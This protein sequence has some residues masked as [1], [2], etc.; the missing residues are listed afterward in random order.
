MSL[1]ILGLIY[2]LFLSCVEFL[3]ASRLKPYLFFFLGAVPL[4]IFLGF[5][6]DV[7]QDYYAYIR[8]FEIA[9]NLANFH[10]GLQTYREQTS[11]V[12]I[13]FAVLASL[14]RTL[15]FTPQGGLFVSAV[16]NI[17][18]VSILILRYGRHYFFSLSI[19][20]AVFLP[21]LF[22]HLR[23]SLCIPLGMLGYLLWMERKRKWAIFLMIFSASFHLTGLIYIATSLLSSF[24]NRFSISFIGG[25]SIF[26]SLILLAPIELRPVLNYGLSLIAERYEFYSNSEGA[27]P[28]AAFLR[29][30]ILFVFMVSLHIFKFEE[31]ADPHEQVLG[32]QLFFA[33]SFSVVLWCLSTHIDIFYRL[34]LALQASFVLIFPLLLRFEKTRTVVSHC[35]YFAM[36]AFLLAYLVYLSF[37]GSA[38]LYDYQV[39]FKIW[40]R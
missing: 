23:F 39:N 33:F 29:L 17:L 14:V 35:C 8:Y 32:K 36:I 11:G 10:Q 2:F 30:A 20:Y 19:Y 6:F 38:V 25:M 24:L 4:C 1:Y 21:T 13:G 26:L 27:G 31:K 16:I 22:T 3:I 28:A 9:P 5:R 15:G 40:G 12:E 18:F 37:T 7:D 34:G